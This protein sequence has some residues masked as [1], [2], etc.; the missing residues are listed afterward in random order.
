MLQT[1]IDPV[2][3]VILTHRIV[4]AQSE[5]NGKIYYFC[6][7]ADKAAFDHN[8]PRYLMNLHKK[9]VPQP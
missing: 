8:P 5:Y 4:F 6:S 3:G 7:Q 2:C 9:L 1:Y